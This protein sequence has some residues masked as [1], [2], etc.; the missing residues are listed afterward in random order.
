MKIFSL[1]LLICFFLNVVEVIGL[2]E[3]PYERFVGLGNCC[4]TKRQIINHLQERFGKDNKT[5]GGGQ[6]FDWLIIHDYNKLSKAL[7]NNL[8]DIFERS[9]LVFDREGFGNSYP[10][11]RNIKYDMTWNHLFTRLEN[12]SLPPNILDLEYDIKKQ[13]IDYLSEKFKNLKHYRT[14]YIVA[15]PFIGS[16][17]LRTTEPDKNTLIRLRNAL[18]QL[19]GNNNFTLLFCPLRQKFREFENVLIRTIVN[20]KDLPPYKGDFNCWNQMLSQF[21]YSLDHSEEESSISP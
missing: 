7:E 3:L 6:L 14:L 16:G 11:I 15:Y 20:S 18:L 5:Y 13:K 21:P 2:E 9:D 12:H 8:S 4:V 10:C 1:L 17:T 19:R